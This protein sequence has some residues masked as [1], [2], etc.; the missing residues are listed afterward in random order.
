MNH[1]CRIALITT[2]AP[3]FALASD[4]DFDALDME[5]LMGSDVQLSSAMKRLQS[6]RETAAS[7][8]VLSGDDI[9]S[10]GADSIPQALKLVPGMQVRQIDNNVWAVSIR[11]SAGVYSSKLLVLVDG[12]SVY[13]PIHAGV[14]WQSLNL[15]LFDIDRI[16]VIRGQGSLLWGSNATNGVVNIITKHSEDT[17]GTKVYAATGSKIDHDLVVRYGNDLDNLGSFRLSAQSRTMSESDDAYKFDIGTND[18]SESESI[19]GRLDL[20]LRDDLFLLVQSQYQEQDIGS[21]IRVPD[22]TT[23]V[24]TPI[25]DEDNRRN[26]SLMSRVDHSVDRDTS[27]MLQVAYTG[28]TSKNMYYQEN[29]NTLDIDYQRNALMNSIQFDWGINYRYADLELSETDYVAIENDSYKMEQYGAFIQAQFELSPDELKFIIGNK[30]EHNEMTGW[31]HQPMA[32]LVWTPDSRHTL[33][34]SVSRGVRIPSLIEYSA[35]I[36][37]GGVSVSELDPSL[38]AYEDMYVTQMLKGNEDVEAETSVSKEIGYRYNSTDWTADISLFHTNSNNV[39]A[40][41]SSFDSDS[42]YSLADVFVGLAINDPAA[43][44]DYINNAYVNQTFITDVELETYGGELVLTKQFTDNIKSELGYSYISIDYTLPN[45]NVA[46]LSNDSIIRQWLFK[47]SARINDNHMIYSVLRYEDGEAYETDDFYALDLNWNWLMS[48][49]IMIG[50][51]AN[52]L[53]NN[54]YIEYADTN[55]T[56]TIPSYIEPTVTAKLLLTF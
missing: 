55:M 21:S 16:E 42:S 8:Y 29:N 11:S 47:T 51:S 32:R 33:W 46:T 15:S 35:D 26:Y 6:A 25:T 43:L 56:F 39:T 50:L 45:S 30:S 18:Y 49:Q 23:H 37:V 13:D 40:L 36:T 10:A 28:T 34:G 27:Q 31:E 41:E 53:L 9:I 38:S 54:S 20:N 2:L 3:T 14:N 52:N 12:L 5:S 1:F 17:R 22:A 7:V 48:Q 24:N 4:L 44:I 19:M